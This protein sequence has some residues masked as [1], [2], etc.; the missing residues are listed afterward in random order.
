M[1]RRRT[2]RI[3]VTSAMTDEQWAEV[4]NRVYSALPSDQDSAVY[5]NNRRL[6]RLAQQ[7]WDH[8]H[9]SRWPT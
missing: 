7:Q 4:L 2:V 6:R 9:Q 3:E 8:D 1:K 5:V